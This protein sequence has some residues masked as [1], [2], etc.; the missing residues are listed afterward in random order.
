MKNVFSL[1][2]WPRPI[3]LTYLIFAAW[4]GVQAIPSEGERTNFVVPNGLENTPGNSFSREIFNQGPDIFQQAYSSSQFAP[5]SPM[6]ITAIT[7][8]VDENETPSFNAVIPGLKI[9]VSTYRQSLSGLSGL[10]SNNRGADEV[11]VFSGDIF[12]N[13]RAFGTGQANPFDLRI[14][15]N[16]PFNYTPTSGHLLLHFENLGIPL[17]SRAVDSQDYPFGDYSVGRQVWM[18][19]FFFSTPN[20]ALIIKFEATVV[21]EPNCVIIF[22]VG[23]AL[24]RLKKGA[25]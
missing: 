6:S 18:D 9:W 1:K 25:K 21:P 7:L 13:G 5:F 23:M 2:S 4:M 22:L 20:E 17:G 15:F 12:L 8:R 24:F 14:P 3:L 16:T 10:A 19:P 11:L